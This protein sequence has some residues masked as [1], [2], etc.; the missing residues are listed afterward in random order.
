MTDL[1]FTS[2]MSAELV[3]QE[4]G[5]DSVIRAA[6]V[7]TANDQEEIS[8]EKRAG[9]INYL[10]KKRHGSPFEHNT[11]TFRVEAPIFVFREWHRHRI[12]WS[13][14][15]TSGRYTTFVPKFY[16]VPANRPLVQEGSSAHPK[17][18]PGSEAHLAIATEEEKYVATVAW[19]SYQKQLN[20]GIAKEVARNVLP[21]EVFTSMY[22]TANARS[23]MSF[24]TLRIDD[25]NNMFE[26]KPQWEIE[27]LGRLMETA[28]ADKMPLTYQAWVKNGR[29]AP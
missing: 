24:L 23:L 29:V 17:L 27:Q 20:Q 14:N 22:A 28:F 6:R 4:G 8:D 9:L 21:V 10:M 5:D 11:F 19:S 26:T 13:Y 3:Q 2:E 12:G 25:E 1:I 16:V 18:V 15:E 7:S